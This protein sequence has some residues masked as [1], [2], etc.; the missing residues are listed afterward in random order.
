MTDEIRNVSDFGKI[1]TNPEK[2]YSC[3][4]PK[5]RKMSYGHFQRFGNKVE[6]GI[7]TGELKL[8][9]GYVP[10]L[11]LD[12][13]LNSYDGS[14]L[15][16]VYICRQCHNEMFLIKHT[17]NGKPTLSFVYSTALQYDASCVPE[18]VNY[19][20][21]QALKS[22]SISAYSAAMAM[23]RSALEFLL[24]ENGFDE[25]RL[26]DK[27]KSFKDNPPAWA[28]SLS[29]QLMGV[30]KDLGNDSVHPNGG[31]I[32]EQE[33]FDFEMLEAVEETLNELIERAYILPQREKERLS[34]LSKASRKTN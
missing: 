2:D 23:Y 25:N 18:G 30:I 8:R 17:I 29:S 24:Y 21:E 27:I 28:T 1:S 11:L 7:I 14:S 19:Y 33:K 9:L 32:S 31:D 3:Y 34:V 22:R 20:M 16:C 5:C 10:D 13:Y 12:L 26:A 4:C 6:L 15:V